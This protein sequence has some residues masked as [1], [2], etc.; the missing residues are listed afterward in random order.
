[1]QKMNDMTA[2]E[3]LKKAAAQ[4]SVLGLSRVSELLR[5]MGDPQDSLSIIHIS[6]TNGKGSFGAMLCSVLKAAGYRTGSFSSPA[7]TSVTD[8]FRINGTEISQAELDR[9]LG[10]IAVH[11]DAMEEKPTEFEVLTAA[12]FDIFRRNG[13]NAVTVECGMG[14]DLDS[15][16][17]IKSPLLSVITNVQKDHCSFLGNTTAEIAGHKAG[18]IKPGRPVYFGGTDLPALEVISARASELGSELFLRRENEV[19][20]ISSDINGI[21]FMYRGELMH[22]PLTGEYQK[23]NI[24]NLLC[25]VEILRG[26]GMDISSDALRDGL[27]NVSW[28]GRFEVLRHEPTVIFDGSHNPDGIAS[29]AESI[30][31]Y[32]P[33]GKVVLLIGVMADKEY[34]LYSSLLGGLVEKAFTVRPDNKRA[35]APELL[36]ASLRNGGIPAESFSHLPDGVRAAFSFARDNRLPLIAMGSLYMYREFTR[37]LPWE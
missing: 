24:I 3:L 4:G 32:F 25:A 14:G 11:W 23:D 26:Q 30:R 33:G 17:V 1:M 22:T 19:S 6:G 12:A 16:N 34:S 31:C 2:S 9:C 28:H 36:A 18:I 35:L 27:E 13:C 21:S 20:F 8:C 10:D 29:A 5:R 7:I 15:T 37:S